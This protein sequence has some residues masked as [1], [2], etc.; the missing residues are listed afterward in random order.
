MK[1]LTAGMAKLLIPHGI[2]GERHCARTNSYTADVQDKAS[3]IEH[4][5]N[6]SGRFAMRRK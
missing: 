4:P 6:P 2:V 3:T 5:T 1:E